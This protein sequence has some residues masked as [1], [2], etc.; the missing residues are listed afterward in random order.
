MPH[1]LIVIGSKYHLSP[2]GRG[3]E[4]SERVR[5]IELRNSISPHP[6]LRLRLQIDLSPPGRGE[7]N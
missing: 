7:E 1:D 3:R 6:I 2:V 4:R 5:G